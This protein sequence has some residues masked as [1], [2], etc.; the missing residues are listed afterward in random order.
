MRNNFDRVL[1]KANITRSQL[2]MMA[3]VAHRPGATQ[4]TIAEALDLSEASS[5]RLIDRLC[6]EGL[7]ER[8]KLERDRRARAVFL[9]P[10]ADPLL[11]MGTEI[12]HD[13]TR[14]IFAGLERSELDTLER[15][16]DKIY[17]NLSNGQ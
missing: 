7:L 17:D 16:L 4:R 10:K 5:G 1:R 11:Q 15:L 2:V 6:A 14:T 12:A 13:F 3:V 9:T 8:R